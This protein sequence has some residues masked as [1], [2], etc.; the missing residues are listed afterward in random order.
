MFRI[1]AALLIR[2]SNKMEASVKSTI[3]IMK[4]NIEINKSEIIAQLNTFEDDI[5]FL[6]GSLV[7][8]MVNPL[9]KGMGNR[10]SDIDCYVMTDSL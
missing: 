9:A 10:L 3:Q 2:F 8:E 5:V 7:E 4:K 6:S 1:P